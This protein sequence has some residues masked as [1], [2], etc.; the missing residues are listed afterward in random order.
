M[1][2]TWLKMTVGAIAGIWLVGF[3]PAPAG[4][5]RPSATLFCPLASAGCDGRLSVGGAGDCS[6]RS[7]D[8]APSVVRSWVLACAD[9]LG[10]S[11][12]PA[13]AAAHDGPGRSLSA[14]RLMTRLQSR[15]RQACVADA[16]WR[17]V[18][19]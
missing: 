15:V 4:D 9:E 17:Q 18:R 14:A 13:G 12:F 7:A 10:R 1:T 19:E 2:A 16:A 11:C 8:L 6:S 5:A 3:G